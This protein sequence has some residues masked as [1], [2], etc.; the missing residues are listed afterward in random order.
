MRL[1]ATRLFAIVICSVCAFAQAKPNAQVFPLQDATG[2][3][4]TKAKA[5]AAEYLGRKAV[6]LTVAGDD[7]DGIALL[8]GTDFQDGTIQAELAVKVTTA[9][10]GR[11]PGFLGIAFRARDAEH[12]ELFY[13]R[14][15]N[16]SAP[17]QLQRNHAVQY[18][19]SPGFGWYHLR[20]EWPG[21]YE[22]GADI[23]PETWTKLKIEVAGRTARL[24]LNDSAK[25]SL[26]VD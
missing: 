1:I 4:L 24:Y 11:N 3:V 26:I 17:D 23:A 18:G 10:G 6:K 14:P 21:L 5:E 13:I 8:P 19:A 25:P 2:L 20:R 7:G 15:G 16:A 22:S 12:L 9:P